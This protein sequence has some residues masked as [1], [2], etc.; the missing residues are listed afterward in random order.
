MLPSFVLDL[1]QQ[2]IGMQF[3]KTHWFDI[4]FI[5]SFPILIMLWKQGN[6]FDNVSSLLWLSLVSLFWH[7]FEEYRYPGYFIRMLNT[8]MYKSDNPASYPLNP[9]TSLIVNGVMGWTF[10]A[11][12]A[13]F[14]QQA[15]WLGIA[16]ILVS[17]GNVIAHTFLFNIKGKTLYNPGMATAILLFLPLACRF[18]YIIHQQQLVTSLDYVIGVPLGI[19]LNVMIL[20]LIDWLKNIR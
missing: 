13:L 1:N 5:L 3:I 2:N 4:G 11:A 20:K 9:F 14:Y 19:A 16:T 12:A 6:F 10:Y 15:L 18:F 7:Q 17:M 8:V